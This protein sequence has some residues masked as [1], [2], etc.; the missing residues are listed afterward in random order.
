M[1][2]SLFLLLALPINLLC[3]LN[4]GF[5]IDFTMGEILILFLLF[6]LLFCPNLI[7]VYLFLLLSEDFTECKLFFL[8]K[9]FIV[10]NGFNCFWI[11]IVVLFKLILLYKVGE[12]SFDKS[13]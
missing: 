9:I 2:W 13:S 3:E 11:C 1:S 6:K 12:C 4:K 10:F 8:D 5:L 7:F